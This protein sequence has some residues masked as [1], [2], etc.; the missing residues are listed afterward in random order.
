MPTPFTHLEIAQRFL[1]DEALP[2]PL[3]DTIARRSG[4][5]LLGSIAADA[6]VGS[7]AKREDTHFYAYGQPINGP[8]W[9]HMTDRYPHLLTPADHAHRA[10]MA[11]YVAHL[12]VDEYWT[13]NLTHPHFALRHWADQAER[14]YMLH[15]LLI[16]MD[17]RDLDQLEGWQPDSLC[18][19][20]PDG[21]LPFMTDS[22]LRNWQQLIYDQIRPGGDS[23]TL[24][25]FGGRISKSPEEMQAIIDNPLEIQARLWDHIPRAFVAEVEAGMYAYAREQMLIYWHRTA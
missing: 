18:A 8:V 1:R 11:G 22:D 9:E 4:A 6:R 19:A 21:W 12:S 13:R 5:F 2:Q 24:E 14:F 15:I 25:I 23:Q 7:G 16:I 20:N 3:R 17:Q 10:F